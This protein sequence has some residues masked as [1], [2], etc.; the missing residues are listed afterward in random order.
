MLVGL[1]A[2]YGLAWNIASLDTGSYEREHAVEWMSEGGDAT[3]RRRLL[4][5]GY[6][7]EQRFGSLGW[8]GRAAHLYQQWNLF[9]QG[10]G[11]RGGWHV[12]RGTLADGREVD[13]LSERPGTPAEPDSAPA[14]T[15]PLYPGIRWRVYF[16]YL[17]QAEQARPLL[18]RVL[19]D[20]WERA[21]PDHP[22]HELEVLFLQRRDGASSDGT[23]AEA[24][25]WF[26][27]EV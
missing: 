2:L 19:A 25:V 22:L 5:P 13:V 15:A 18:P 21:H 17:T 6:A 7:V 20:R 24:S 27:G 4:L 16:K 1:L 11:K 8:I 12:V 26:R 9:E 23:T 14:E 3:F 10:G